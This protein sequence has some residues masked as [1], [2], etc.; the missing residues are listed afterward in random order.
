MKT[1][2]PLEIREHYRI[3]AH[4]AACI[5]QAELGPS[6]GRVNEAPKV[7]PLPTWLQRGRVVSRTLARTHG[8]DG[9][10]AA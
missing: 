10:E 1:L 9:S 5:E 8:G 2:S 6:Q 3:T 4:A 7:R